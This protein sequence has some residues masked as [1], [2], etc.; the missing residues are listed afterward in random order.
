MN[1]QKT[2][3]AEKNSNEQLQQ[4]YSQSAKEQQ[5]RVEKRLPYLLGVTALLIILSLINTVEAAQPITFPI[6][7]I[8]LIVILILGIAQ[9]TNV[10]KSYHD[11]NIAQ[12][13]Q[14]TG[15]DKV[16]IIRSILWRP[17]IILT[18]LVVLFLVFAWF[19]GNTTPN[20]TSTPPQ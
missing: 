8:L 3:A 14:K 17:F 4:K 1:D 20:T 2:T 15:R 6:L 16:G 5:Q 12:K 13:L 11:A 7:I 10:V 9:D 18:I 19:S